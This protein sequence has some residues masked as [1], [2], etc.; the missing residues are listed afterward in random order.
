MSDEQAKLADL[1]GKMEAIV[2]G[3]VAGD[4]AAAS[5]VFNRDEVSALRK[6]IKDVPVLLKIIKL[7]SRLEGFVFVSGRGA[8]VVIF[9]VVLIVNAERLLDFARALLLGKP[10]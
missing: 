5:Y 1:I 7:Y 6:I 10:P 3:G 2:A 8:A 4:A 9:L